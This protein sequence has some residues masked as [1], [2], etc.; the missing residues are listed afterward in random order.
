MKEKEPTERQYLILF[1][2]VF[3]VLLSL[4]LQCLMAM[5][6]DVIA[7]RY[8]SVITLLLAMIFLSYY[9]HKIY[10]QLKIEWNKP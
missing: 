3:G 5:I 2:C 7:K 10:A 1:S 4:L 9:T 8:I 6:A